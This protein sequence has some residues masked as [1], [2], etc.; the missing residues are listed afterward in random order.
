M[1]VPVG[2]RLEDLTIVGE[3]SH[4]RGL[5]NRTYVDKGEAAVEASVP[6]VAGVVE[7]AE[8]DDIVLWD[9]RLAPAPSRGDIVPYGH[10]E[11]SAGSAERVRSF[12]KLVRRL[13][14]IRGVACACDFD[15]SRAVLLTHGAGNVDAAPPAVAQVPGHL[16]EFPGGVVLTMLES[17]WASGERFTTTVEAWFATT[18]M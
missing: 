3:V 7:H 11:T 5:P 10:V 2:N 12:A 13:E 1:G 6:N 4:V 8:P 9:R 14:Q 17:D 15:T 18:E 16:A